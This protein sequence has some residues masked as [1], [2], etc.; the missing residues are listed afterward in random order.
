MYKDKV[1]IVD[2]F[3]S[4]KECKMLMKY[5]KDNQRPQL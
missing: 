3:L 2:N 1:W 4:K 5:H